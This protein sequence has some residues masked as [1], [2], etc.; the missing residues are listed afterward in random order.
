MLLEKCVYPADFSFSVTVALA[1]KNT[2][3]NSLSVSGKLLP[4]RHVT[5]GSDEAI[6]FRNV[7]A[8][9]SFVHSSFT[10][11]TFLF[12]STNDVLFSIT[13][14]VL[15][16]TITYCSSSFLHAFQ[17]SSTELTKTKNFQRTLKAYWMDF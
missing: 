9:S 6:L 12:L 7:M 2:P 10:L 16:F 17:L 14:F 11:F 8:T 15:C 13:D 1:N 5:T 4:R 3:T